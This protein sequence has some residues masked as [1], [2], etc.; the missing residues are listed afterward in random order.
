MNPSAGMCVV[1]IAAESYCRISFNEEK[2]RRFCC[3]VLRKLVSL[4]EAEYH[5]FQLVILKDSAN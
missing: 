3:C 4:P 5:R 1:K 2:H